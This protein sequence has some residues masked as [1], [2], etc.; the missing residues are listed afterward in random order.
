MNEEICQRCQRV[1][2]QTE[3]H[4]HWC[5]AAYGYVV[6][7]S[8]GCDTG[9]CGHGIYV[10]DENDKVMDYEFSFSH[11]DSEEGRQ[12]FCQEEL[13]EHFPGILCDL[14]RCEAELY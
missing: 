5:K 10:C 4:P 2:H 12:A 7:D 8:Y 3:K 6:H 14:S 9:C 11:P 1:V 13:E